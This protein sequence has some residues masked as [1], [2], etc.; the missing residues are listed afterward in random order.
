MKVYELR[1]ETQ[2]NNQ[3]KVETYLYEEE[4]RCWQVY[5][6]ECALINVSFRR[7]NEVSGRN[8]DGHFCTISYKKRSV[9]N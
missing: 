1:L 8:E 3:T 6:Q 2:A 9:N 7:G 5:Q 4:Y